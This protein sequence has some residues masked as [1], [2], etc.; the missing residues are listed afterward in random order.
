[1]NYDRPHLPEVRVGRVI[2][3]HRMS[4]FVLI[5]CFLQTEP[6]RGSTLVSSSLVT[7]ADV[8]R[9][10]NIYSIRNRPHLPEV[11]VGRCFSCHRLAHLRAYTV[12]L[13]AE[14]RRGSTLVL[15]SSVTVSDVPRWCNFFRILCW[16][17]CKM[18]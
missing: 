17:E 3:C 10:R 18:R 16:Y 11:R 4:H 13:I 9:W 14:P 6:R 2:S 1:M 7:V 12:L 15:S 8:P 5:R